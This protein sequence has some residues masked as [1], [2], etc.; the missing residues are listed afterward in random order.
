MG[1][2]D[3]VS[4]AEITK[5]SSAED[6]WVVVNGKV[7]DLSKVGMYHKSVIKDEADVDMTVRS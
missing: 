3:K 7:Y 6:C 1:Q 5:H 4:V 2:G